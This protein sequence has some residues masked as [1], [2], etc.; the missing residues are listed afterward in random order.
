ML[1]I[2]GRISEIIIDSVKTIGVYILLALDIKVSVLVFLSV[3]FCVNSNIWATMEFSKV[4]VA[5]ISITFSK[6]IYP[7]N[8]LSFSFIVICSLSPVSA[9]E[10]I[11]VVPLITSPSTGTNSPFFIIRV[12]PILTSSTFIFFI[13]LSI[14]I[15]A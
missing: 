10:L 5:I 13:L 1:L 11:E 3:A 14:F 9:D 2:R 6:F 4:A 8:T 12:S 7:D 15:L